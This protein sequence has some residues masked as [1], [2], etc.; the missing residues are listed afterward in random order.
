MGTKWTQSLTIDSRFERNPE[1]YLHLIFLSGKMLKHY[2]VKLYLIA[3]IKKNRYVT[4]RE[5][6]L[7]KQNKYNVHLGSFFCVSANIAALKYITTVLEK[8]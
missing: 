8:W 3:N 5:Y 2:I 4:H 6:V 7:S 1:V